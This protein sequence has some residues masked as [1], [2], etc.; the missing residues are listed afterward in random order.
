MQH[1]KSALDLPLP[2]K[3]EMN[4]GSKQYFSVGRGSK[5]SLSFQKKTDLSSEFDQMSVSTYYEDLDSSFSTEQICENFG[6]TPLDDSDL[7]QESSGLHSLESSQNPDDDNY[8]DLDSIIKNLLENPTPDKHLQLS[9][10]KK[11]SPFAKN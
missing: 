8:E 1:V 10:K 11:V 2:E 5:K 4:H 7:K 3:P 9:M 6:I